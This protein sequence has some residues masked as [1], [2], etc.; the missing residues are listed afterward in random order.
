MKIAF[1]T[2]ASPNWSWEQTLNAAAQL[3]YDGIELRGV[4]GEMYLPRARPFYPKI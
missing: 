3:G 4:E 1:Q 2:L